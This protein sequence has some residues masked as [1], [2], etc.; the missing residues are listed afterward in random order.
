[1]RWRAHGT[2]SGL[3]RSAEGLRCGAAASAAAAPVKLG[4]RFPNAV[5]G[6]VRVP[7]DTDTRA[8]D[9]AVGVLG[10]ELCALDDA[11]P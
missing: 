6:G 9:S 10:L 7:S 5:A 2:P 11:A 8:G 1:M 3:E 4:R